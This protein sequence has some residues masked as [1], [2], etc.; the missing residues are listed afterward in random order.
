[1][2][3]LM[4]G[5]A[6]T[7]KQA[8]AILDMR[9][10]RL[11]GLEVE[12]INEE[13]GFL[14]DQIAY[15]NL[16]LSN[17]EEVKKIIIKEITEIKEK[18]ATPRLS[19]LTYDYLSVRHPRLRPPL[20]R[21]PPSFLERR[22][23]HREAARHP[24]VLVVEKVTIA[25]GRSPASGRPGGQCRDRLSTPALFRGPGEPS[26]CESAP[27]APR[28]HAAVPATPAGPPPRTIRQGN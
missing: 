9:L 18:Y 13:L 1:M 11:T 19:E 15:F 10:Q 23:P 26:T 3:K 20:Q 2:Q 17:D 14:T 16:V 24:L 12:K 4:D 8:A 7:D 25:P 28:R 5:Y 6:L 21:P 22:A 27:Q